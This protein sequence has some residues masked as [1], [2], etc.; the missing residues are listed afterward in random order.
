MKLKNSRS[1][2]ERAQRF[3]M[4]SPWWPKCVFVLYGFGKRGRGTWR[5]ELKPIA[6][7][8]SPLQM[9]LSLACKPRT[10]WLSRG[11][12]R[13]PLDD[14]RWVPLS[15]WFLWTFWILWIS[16]DIFGSNQSL[17][18]SCWKMLTA[19]WWALEPNM[20]GSLQQSSWC[21]NV[22]SHICKDEIEASYSRICPKGWCFPVFLCFPARFSNGF[23]GV[24]YCQPINSWLHAAFLVPKGSSRGD[25]HG[26][27]N[28][29]NTHQ[30]PKVDEL[31]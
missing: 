19:C 8:V 7:M 31:R 23:V 10:P 9:L 16:L 13:A 11:S 17:E 12:W 24:G 1:R 5:K 22:S 14:F 28:T 20:S 2:I 15:F 26:A 27:E 4:V 29:Q 30:L 21:H 6:R 18:I 25:L 3:H